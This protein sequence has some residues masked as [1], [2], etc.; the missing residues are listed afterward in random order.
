MHCTDRNVRATSYTTND[1][2]AVA[3]FLCPWE[4]LIQPMLK[5]PVHFV[6]Q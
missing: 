5:L 2:L 1:L 6:L 3:S 4:I